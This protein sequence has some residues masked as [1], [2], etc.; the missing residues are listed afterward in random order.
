MHE[1]ARFTAHLPDARVRFLPSLG[2]GVDER[3]EEAPV[4]VVGGAAHLVP[5]PRQV[6]EVPVD[7]E[8][9]LLGGGVADAHGCRALVPLERELELDQA[10]LSADAVHDLQVVDAARRAALDEAAEPVGLPLETQLAQRAN[11]ELR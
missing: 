1:V 10:A 7:I 8:L 6:E 5:L 4:V 3:E 9:Q 11:G 2:G